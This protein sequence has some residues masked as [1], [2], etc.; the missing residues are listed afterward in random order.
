MRLPLPLLITI[1]ACHPAPPTPMLYDA[2]DVIVDAGAADAIRADAQ[3]CQLPCAYTGKC[4]A[5]PDGGIACV[6]TA[7]SCAASGKCKEHGYCQVDAGTC[8][9]AD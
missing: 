8:Q 5:N 4:Y 7:E 2:G 6:A 9:Q 1:A 3:H